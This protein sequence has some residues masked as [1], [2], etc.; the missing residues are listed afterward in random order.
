VDFAFEAS[1]PG[2]VVVGAVQ[3]D[4]GF[5]FQRFPST[6]HSLADAKVVWTFARLCPVRQKA[7]ER[8]GTYAEARPREAAGFAEDETARAPL[9]WPEG[10]H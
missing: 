4:R 9:R 2:V 6:V 3:L 1:K 10:G 8:A 5:F 7:G